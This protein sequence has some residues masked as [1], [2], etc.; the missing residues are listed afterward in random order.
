[1]ISWHLFISN[2][3]SPLIWRLSRLYLGYDLTS[4]PLVCIRLL[5][6]G[7]DLQRRGIDE[8]LIGEGEREGEDGGLYALAE[9][10]ALPSSSLAEFDL[11]IDASL[12]TPLHYPASARAVMSSRE[13]HL[14]IVCDPKSSTHS[15]LPALQHI[16]NIN[17]HC[18]KRPPRTTAA[19]QQPFSRNHGNN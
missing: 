14:V 19:A 18:P 17:Q 8:D 6:L 2:H 1:M 7:F 15:R 9:N 11:S 4:R 13:A 3:E 16:N 10:P 12:P 5:Q